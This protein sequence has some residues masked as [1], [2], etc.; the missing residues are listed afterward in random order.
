MKL[1][2]NELYH[3]YIYWLI[4]NLLM[5]VVKYMIILKKSKKSRTIDKNRSIDYHHNILFKSAIN[6]IIKYLI[7]WIWI[8]L[9]ISFSYWNNFFIRWKCSKEFFYKHK[10]I[11]W[12]SSSFHNSFAF[13][14]SFSLKKSNLLRKFIFNSLQWLEFFFL[15]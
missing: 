4:N 7:L 5:N 12:I 14:E 1:C 8:F 9:I 2:L 6:N 13:I 10:C 15:K 11:G 3:I